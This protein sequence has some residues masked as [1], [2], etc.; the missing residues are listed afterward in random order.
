MRILHYYNNGFKPYTIALLMKETD[1][2]KVSR[3]GVAKFLKLYLATGCI[4]RKPGSGRLCKLTA[5]VKS[6]VETQMQK[7]DETTA[8][9]LHRML[10]DNGIEISLRTILR[11]R[12]A[13]GWTFRGSAYCQLIRDA[14]KEKRVL[15]ANEYKD[16]AFENVMFTDE[17]TIQLENHRRFSCRKEGQLPKPKPRYVR[18]TCMHA[19]IA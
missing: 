17:A 8:T 10:N 12:T 1:D 11:C 5:R 7:D 19:C 13:L 4:G 2:I 9:Q 18:Y 3:F 15:W 6:L 14:N 16:D